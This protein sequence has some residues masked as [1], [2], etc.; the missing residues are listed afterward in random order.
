MD[1]TGSFAIAYGFVIV[2]VDLS[3]LTDGSF[4][5]LPSFFPFF[6][7]LRFFVAICFPLG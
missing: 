1:F 2:K 3:V 7:G 6:M 5:P 4:F